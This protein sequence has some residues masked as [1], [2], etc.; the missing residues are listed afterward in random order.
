MNT[1]LMRL[2]DRWVGIPCCFGLTLWEKSR[3]LFG[4]RRPLPKP[5]RRILFIELAET[6]GIVVACP[7]L[8]YARKTFPDA[9]IFFMT[10]SL[11]KGI[12]ELLEFPRER[13]IILR[14]SSLGVF[15]ADTLAALRQIRRLKFDAVVNLETFAR[16]SSLLGYLSGAP[17]RSGFYRFH[18]EGRYTGELLTHRL[19]YNPHVHAG[20]TFIALVA[21]LLETPQQEPLLKKDLGEESLELPT[22]ASSPRARE[23]LVAKLRELYPALDMERH[24]L[25]LLNANASDL[26]AARRWPDEY[27]L[28]LGRE[29]LK[30]PDVC[31]VF[32]GA[33]NEREAVTQLAAR[34][35]HERVLNMAGR[36]DDLS[37]LIDLYN[38]SSLLVTNDSGPAHFAS[39]TSLNVIVLFGP[40][41]PDIYGPLGAEVEAV[42]LGLACSPCVSAYN[43]KRSPCSDNQCLKM[44]SPELVLEK[45]KAKLARQRVALDN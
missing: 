37:Q 44:I 34:L 23:K 20:Q 32:T 1:D 11:G 40:E 16:F 4:S 43:Q 29:L 13:Q 10:F 27:F 3:R 45:A 19:I 24:K 41:T 9:E 6:G 30:D 36:T 35:P 38:S 33:P 18:D 22:V 14:T 17:L 39:L 31:I 42:Y 21:A 7:A 15:V 25:V 5:P 26:V 2:V 28:T 12:L 8:E